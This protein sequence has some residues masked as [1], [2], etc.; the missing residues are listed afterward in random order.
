MGTPVPLEH[1]KLEADK[2]YLC[3]VDSYEGGPHPED[4]SADYLWRTRCCVSGAHLT[5]W[6]DDGWEC[7]GPHELC[8]VSGSSAQR[9]VAI[10]GPY[11][12]VDACLS[13][14]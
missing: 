9:L 11:E 13:D 8:V 4:C 10:H 6:L 1:P 14:L 12:D 2:T 7:K 5:R 3:V